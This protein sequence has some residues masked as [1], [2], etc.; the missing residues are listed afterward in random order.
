MAEKREEEID[1]E[2]VCENLGKL[3]G[4]LKEAVGST[5]MEE[6]RVEIKARSGLQKEEIEKALLTFQIK[7]GDIEALQQIVFTN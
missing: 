2:K 5:L 1:W 4:T 7:K 6:I 3:S